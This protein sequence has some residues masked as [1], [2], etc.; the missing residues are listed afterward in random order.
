MVSKDRSKQSEKE[1]RRGPKGVLNQ[2]YNKSAGVGGMESHKGTNK[3]IMLP[4]DIPL[5]ESPL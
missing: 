3:T 2:D 4:T 5:I 1:S